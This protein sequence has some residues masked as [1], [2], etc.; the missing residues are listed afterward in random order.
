VANIAA[1]LQIA[2]DA[3]NI[4]GKTNE[5]LGFLGRREGIAVTTVALLERID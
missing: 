1:D 5:G 3:V 4:K 2:T